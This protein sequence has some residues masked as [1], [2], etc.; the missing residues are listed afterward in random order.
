MDSPGPDD[1]STAFTEGDRVEYADG[2][3]GVVVG[4]VPAPPESD[5]PRTEALWKELINRT[6]LDEYDVSLTSDDIADPR[7]VVR[8]ESGVTTVFRA[9][10][11]LGHS[12]G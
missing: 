12:V 6:V 9:D 3:T 10:E 4:V 2:K 5:D 1:E 8:R 7:C 11:L